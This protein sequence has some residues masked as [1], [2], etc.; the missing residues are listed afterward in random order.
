MPVMPAGSGMQCL[1]LGGHTGVAN[2]QAGGWVGG[3]MGS[4]V[5][6]VF[7]CAGMGP[8]QCLTPGMACCRCWSCRGRTT[9]R[10]GDGHAARD[11]NAT[12]PSM[13]GKLG[14]AWVCVPSCRSCW[15]SMTF[16]HSCGQK[17]ALMPLWDTR[18]L[19]SDEPA[20]AGPRPAHGGQDWVA[21][22]HLRT[23]LRPCQATHNAHVN[24][25]QLSQPGHVF[26]HAG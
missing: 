18:M 6:H 22:P 16:G 25:L 21:A 5:V 26:M 17:G 9:M 10:C 20:P 4:G 3:H 12:G 2:E 13:C 24:T 19:T 23:P 7:V 11:G 1:R 14:C 8:R 15:A